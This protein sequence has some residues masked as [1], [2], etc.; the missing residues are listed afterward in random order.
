M[1]IVSLKILRIFYG[2]DEFMDEEIMEAL[3]ENPF[4]QH[5]EISK[6]TYQD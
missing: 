5:R 6:D 2:D 1:L 3:Y 4:Q